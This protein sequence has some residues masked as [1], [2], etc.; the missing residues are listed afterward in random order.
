MHMLSRKDLN[1]AE[2]ETVRVS[3][4]PTKVITA[5]GESA[6]ERGSNGA[7]Q[8]FDSTTPRRYTASS[9]FDRYSCPVSFERIFELQCGTSAN[10][11][12]ITGLNAR[13]IH[14]ETS[15]MK[16]E[17]ES[18]IGSRDSEQSLELIESDSSAQRLEWLLEFSE[19]WVER[20]DSIPEAASPREPSIPEPRPKV[21]PGK[22]NVLTHFPQDG[23]CKVC[24]R[25]KFTRAPCRKRASNSILRAQNVGDLI[26]ADH[27][28]LSEEG[29]YRN[30]H[31]YAVIVQDL[32]TQW[33]QS[34]PC[35]TKTSQ[36]TERV[37]KSFSN[38][39][40]V[41]K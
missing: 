19:Y 25:T 11:V 13:G 8:G 1:A 3:R 27:K 32:A 34:Y 33:I 9:S 6:N 2:L 12:F 5:K 24:K 22:H 18:T 16:I 7:C 4:T 41:Q 30:N 37:I 20:E 17:T 39:N 21:E 28:V 10:Y 35:K 23:K 38:P 26:T 14:A 15:E 31:R 36:E 29:E 40:P